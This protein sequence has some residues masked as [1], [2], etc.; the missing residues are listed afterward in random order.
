MQAVIR[1]M[2]GLEQLDFFGVGFFVVVDLRILLHS[3]NLSPS[4]CAEGTHLLKPLF[5]T[6]VPCLVVT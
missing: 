4:L 3:F 1:K 6:T 5:S 2:G